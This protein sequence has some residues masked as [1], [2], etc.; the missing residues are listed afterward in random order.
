M[1]EQTRVMPGL[2]RAARTT[3]CLQLVMTLLITVILLLGVA[4]AVISGILLLLV[5]YAVAACVVIGLV[6]VKMGTRRTWVRWAAVAVQGV[7]AAGQMIGLLSDPGLGKMT[8]LAL[9]VA[10]IACLLSP[11]SDAWFNVRAGAPEGTTP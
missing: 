10:A 9:A 8:G 3:M 11:S 6:V 5:L 7:L 2:V 4:Q 1:D